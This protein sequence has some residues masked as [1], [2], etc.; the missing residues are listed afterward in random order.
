MAR[1]GV[2][3][4]VIAI[5]W[6]SGAS[7]NLLA[8]ALL[9]ALVMTVSSR[10][11]VVAFLLAVPTALV[12]AGAFALLLYTS[13]QAG[14]RMVSR[15]D[16]VLMLTG[17]VVY[18]AALLHLLPVPTSA[19]ER[20]LVLARVIVLVGLPV[21]A[22]HHIRRERRLRA[23][24]ERLR[25]RLRIARDMHDSLG[26]LLSVVSIQ[27][28]A[29]EVSQLPPDQ[30]SRVRTLAK[31]TR[32]AVDELHTVVAALRTE[33]PGLERI[34]DVVTQF[35][36]AGVTIAVERSGTAR[37][38]AGTAMSHAAYRVCQ[39]GLTN[40]VKHAPGE[41]VVISFDWQPDALLLNVTNP[42]GGQE[43]PSSGTGILGLAERV[44]AAGGLLRAHVERD[45]FRLVAMLPLTVEPREV[46]A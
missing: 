41:P 16:H 4:A 13:Y 22:G 39:E 5:D 1:V 42:V 12:S 9:A 35:R 2:L 14:H 38:L 11:P 8:Y 10:L 28:A 17:A 26:Q 36:Q 3:V 33:P 31:A 37:P 40:A 32:S 18:L 45:E 6:V 34:D 21:L 30:R 7:W 24:Q 15:R 25:E 46:T 43:N 44:A 19:S 20:W 23:D 27:A 29:L